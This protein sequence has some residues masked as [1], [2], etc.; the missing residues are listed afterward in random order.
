V[1]V[2]ISDDEF[3]RVFEANGAAATG[4]IIGISERSVHKRR[5]SLERRGHSLTAP[6]AT[7]SLAAWSWL[8]RY[9]LLA[10]RFC[11]YCNG[12]LGLCSMNN[13]VSIR[14]ATHGPFSNTADIAQQMKELWRE[15]SGWEHLSP[16]RR[17]ALE[18]IASKIARIL[19]GNAN[20][21]DHWLDISGYAE[22]GRTNGGAT[23]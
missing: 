16:A 21:P 7:N 6:C 23:G 22:L 11:N 1:P 20:E 17:E 3:I 19:A 2:P 5:V 13:I 15:T 9:V 8:G 18:H 14:Q 10:F 4:R 12:D